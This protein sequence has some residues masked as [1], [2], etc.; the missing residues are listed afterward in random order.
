MKNY[1]TIL[2]PKLFTSLPL[3]R[4]TPVKEPETRNHAPPQCAHPRHSAPSQ[5]VTQV[6]PDCEGGGRQGRQES[7]LAHPRKPPGRPRA[8]SGG[9]GAP[10]FVPQDGWGAR[11][12][13]AKTQG[14]AYAP[15]PAG[16]AGFLG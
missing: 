16:S 9:E 4:G 12:L 15:P 2:P 1:K 8:G 14:Q 11:E 7:G 5:E 10:H 13:A 6:G 3:L